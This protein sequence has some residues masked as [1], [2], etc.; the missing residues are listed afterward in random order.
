[1]SIIIRTNILIYK[2]MLPRRCYGY[3]LGTFHKCRIVLWVRQRCIGRIK[4]ASVMQLIIYSASFFIP[5]T[6]T[7]YAGS[8]KHILPGEIIQKLNICGH[9]FSIFWR[10]PFPASISLIF[11]SLLFQHS[12]MFPPRL[13]SHSFVSPS[14]PGCLT[15]RQV[16]IRL[17]L[18][19][20][21]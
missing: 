8:V 20:V 19:A 5:L 11:L 21:V 3:G 16:T 10:S 2:S 7:T 18:E 9:H 4:T 15:H 12:K 17:L 14:F 13:P 1:M 6:P